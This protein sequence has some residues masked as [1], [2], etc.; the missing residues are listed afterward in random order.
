MCRSRPPR[1][2]Q[3]VDLR[4]VEAGI[5]GVLAVN[6]LHDLGRLRP[7]ADFGVEKRLHGG[8]EFT[9]QRRGGHHRG[10]KCHGGQTHAINLSWCD[11]GV[12]PDLGHPD[13]RAKS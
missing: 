2:V 1:E 12:G 3:R 7:C 13:T 8:I 5:L 4:L 10:Q 6:R 11:T 9:G